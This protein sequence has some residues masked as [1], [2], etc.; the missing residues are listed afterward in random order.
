[1]EG[2]MNCKALNVMSSGALKG[3]GKYLQLHFSVILFAVCMHTLSVAGTL[4]ADHSPV[5]LPCFV[6]VLL[7]PVGQNSVNAV[8]FAGDSNISSSR[9]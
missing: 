4:T 8:L 9:S 6:V 5:S 7:L 2:L 1:M 3:K